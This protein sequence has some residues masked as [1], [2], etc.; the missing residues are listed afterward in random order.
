MTFRI[1]ELLETLSLIDMESG[2]GVYQ[3]GDIGLFTY[4][5][6]STGISNLL[7]NLG[8]GDP[9]DRSPPGP[10]WV[11][12]AGLKSLSV[13]WAEPDPR[14]VVAFLEKAPVIEEICITG[15]SQGVPNGIVTVAGACNPPSFKR[16]CIR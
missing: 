13:S 5:H 1:P 12:M 16:L 14:A 15:M 3:E 6:D 10:P 9:K 7:A 4:D 2:F 8:L 11:S